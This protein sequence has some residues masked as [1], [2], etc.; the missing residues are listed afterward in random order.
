MKKIVGHVEEGLSVGHMIMMLVIMFALKNSMVEESLG[1]F[2][3]TRH[4]SGSYAYRL[5]NAYWKKRVL[6]KVT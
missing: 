6:E 1:H 4:S 3:K 5:E 2:D